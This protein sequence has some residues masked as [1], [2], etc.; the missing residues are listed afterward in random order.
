[1]PASG[2]CCL[3]VNGVGGC[4][5][6]R[7]G[8]AGGNRRAEQAPCPDVQRMSPP[9]PHL[10]FDCAPLLF[11]PP[12][13]SS[14]RSCRSSRLTAARCPCA[15]SPR[16][17]SSHSSSS[18]SSSSHS[19][20]SCPGSHST[21]AL[22]PSAS[23]PRPASSPSSTGPPSASCA[24]ARTPSCASDPRCHQSPLA[25]GRC[26][27]HRHR[28]RRHPRQSRPRRRRLSSRRPTLQQRRRRPSQQQSL[29]MSVRSRS[30]CQPAEHG[31]FPF[32]GPPPGGASLQLMQVQEGERGGR[33]REQQHQ[34]CDGRAAHYPEQPTDL[35]LHWLCCN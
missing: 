16:P 24:P 10:L 33:Q 6:S 26:W 4:I 5:V 35:S 17:E 7:E 3:L 29:S 1:M 19:C 9:G 18:S 34:H 8:W 14:C 32:G 28:H 11:L 2:A 21:G 27:T 22:C 12:S 20:R 25:C 23:S 30:R 13:F 15:S 31:C